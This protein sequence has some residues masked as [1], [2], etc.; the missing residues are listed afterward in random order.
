ELAQGMFRA[1][2]DIAGEVTTQYIL[3]YIP[4]NT[5]DKKQFRKVEVVV[6]LPNVKVRARKGYYPFTP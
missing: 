3:R 4:Q 1:I 5:D 2:T 6:N